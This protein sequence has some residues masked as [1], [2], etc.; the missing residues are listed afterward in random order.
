MKKLERKQI[1]MKN[2]IKKIT[3]SFLTILIT[4]L[5]STFSNVVSAKIVNLTVKQTTQE[6]QMKNLNTDI[7]K[8]INKYRKSKKCKAFK[9]KV[10][11]NSN[12]KS[13]GKR[14]CKKFRT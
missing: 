10:K 7:C 1:I 9:N 12:G 6:Y 2:K 13:Q 5:S 11:F 14:N 8:Q 4:F 3:A